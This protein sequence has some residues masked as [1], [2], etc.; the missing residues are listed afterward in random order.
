MG[1]SK[2]EDT[3]AVRR[4][5]GDVEELSPEQLE[6]LNYQRKVRD[7]EAT[8]RL[9]TPKQINIFAVALCVAVLV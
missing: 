9:L 6:E 3:I 1:G 5:S 8:G 2:D 4:S 7:Q